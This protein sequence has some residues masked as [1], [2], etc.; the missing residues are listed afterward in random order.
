MPENKETK[1]AILLPNLRAGGAERVSVNLAN[2]LASRGYLVDVVLFDLEGELVE[3]L[4]SDVNVVGLSAPRIRSGFVPLLSLIRNGNYDAV[5]ACMWPLTVM[6]VLA[7]LFS[8]TKTRIILVEHCTWSMSEIIRSTFHRWIIRLSM[9]ILFPFADGIIAVSNGASDDLARFAYIQ[10]RNITTI[11]NPVVSPK[12]AMSTIAKIP[13]RWLCDGHLRILA[14][15]TLKAVKDFPTLLRAFSELRKNKDVHL[16]IL[17]EGK[18]RQQLNEIVENLRISEYVEMPGFVADTSAYFEHADLFVLT[19]ISEALPTVLIEALDAGIPIV[20]TDCP[21]G[22]RE[23][24][25]DGKHGILV[26]VGDAEKLAAAMLQS[27]S[28]THDKEVLKAKAQDF[29]IK[30]AADEYLA[31]LLPEQKIENFRG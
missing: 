21:S 24:L 8:W 5:L 15:G 30:K 11:Y 2:E 12:I 6:A 13:L 22:P 18:C 29:T 7:K 4:N 23:I 17:G 25:E 20:S 3:L 1:I 28:S 10:R 19:S 31:L 16:L 14:V 27:L 9:K 26:P